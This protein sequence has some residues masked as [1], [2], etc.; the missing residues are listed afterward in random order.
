M[1][2]RLTF[3]R[4]GLTFEPDQPPHTVYILDAEVGHVEPH[5]ASATF[6]AATGQVSYNG[7]LDLL[8]AVVPSARRAPGLTR[9]MKGGLDVLL[10][11]IENGEIRRE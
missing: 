1:F 4:L 5:G 9:P 2:G 3:E 10:S 7:E 8:Q 6:D 11:A